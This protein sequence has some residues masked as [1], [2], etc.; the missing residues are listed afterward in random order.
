MLDGRLGTAL[1]VSLFSPVQLVLEIKIFLLF[2]AEVPSLAVVVAVLLQPSHSSISLGNV[3][4]YV[5]L[6]I[7]LDPLFLFLGDFLPSLSV[8]F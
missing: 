3:V 1:S 7:S 4:N 6:R 5:A 8:L 2:I